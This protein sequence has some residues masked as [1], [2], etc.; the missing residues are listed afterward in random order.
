[1]TL[2]I[3]P[4]PSGLPTRLVSRLAF[5]WRGEWFS[6]EAVGGETATFA[7]NATSKDS[8]GNTRQLNRECLAWEIVDWDG[9]SVRETPGLLLGASD[10]IYWSFQRKPT[11]LTVYLEFVENGTKGSANAALFYIGN[12]GNSGARLW[13]DSTGSVY[14]VRH[15]NG[16]AEVTSTL[17]AGPSNGD[18]DAIRVTLGSDGKVQIF[19]SIN[20][21]AETSGSLSAANTLASAW[22][23]TRLYLGTT[24]DTNP[25][26][27]VAVRCRVALGAR[28]AAQLVEAW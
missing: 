23:D 20:G 8:N 28:T 22:S 25:G 3:Y 12:A 15:H 14:R 11:A 2:P 7:R 4:V 17:G 27:M 19:Q 24:G 9:D 5:H 6:A 16:S 1:M 10:K 21:A 18:R 13:I 26:N